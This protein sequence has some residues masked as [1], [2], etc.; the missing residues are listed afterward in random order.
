MH[1]YHVQYGPRRPFCDLPWFGASA[2][3]AHNCGCDYSSLPVASLSNRPAEY[4]PIPMPK[5][6]QYAELDGNAFCAQS[7]FSNRKA[8]VS[9]ADSL[10]VSRS[11]K[12]LISEMPRLLSQW[13][14]S[15]F[16]GRRMLATSP[17]TFLSAGWKK[18]FFLFSHSV[19][20]SDS[21]LSKSVV[22]KHAKYSILHCFT[23]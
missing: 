15:P 13:P 7:S 9:T 20:A 23:T 4:R 12:W 8:E 18:Y 10:E 1:S 19:L 14:N 11:G 3:P 17:L 16:A 5:P 21:Y 22:L 6:R 2:L